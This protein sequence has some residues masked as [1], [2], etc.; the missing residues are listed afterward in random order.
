M[1]PRPTSW[2]LALCTL[3]AAGSPAR[4]MPPATRAEIEQA[5]GPP[6]PPGSGLERAQVRGIPW[7][8]GV[9]EHER[10]WWAPVNNLHRYR[11]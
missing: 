10:E 5:I 2:I 9:R 7:C 6:T 3:L 8:G 11:T 1:T 4:A